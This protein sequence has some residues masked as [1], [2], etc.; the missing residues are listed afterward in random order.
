MLEVVTVVVMIIGFIGTF[1]PAI[2][3]TG[4]VFVS[5]LVYGIITKFN[6]ITVTMTIVFGVLTVVAI[7]LDYS[8]SLITTKKVGASRYGVMGAIIGGIIG[9]IIFNIIGLIIGQSAGAIVGE[10]L[11]SRDLG[12]SIKVGFAT[13][14]GYLLGVVANST[15]SLIIIISFLL[16]VIF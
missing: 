4:L 3:G 11:R 16:K 2:P 9:F 1:I 5:A 14:I 7:I 8:A 13:F 6:D 15:I 12:A 10:L